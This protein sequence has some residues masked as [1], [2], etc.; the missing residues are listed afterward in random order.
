[1]LIKL[2]QVHLFTTTL[3]TANSLSLYRSIQVDA[4][5]LAIFKGVDDVCASAI[6]ID[7]VG[8]GN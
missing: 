8:H 7:K 5:L 4:K 6:G 2:G 3:W 1:M